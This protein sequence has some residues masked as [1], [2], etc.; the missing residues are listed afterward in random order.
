MGDYNERP[1]IFALS[2]PTSKAECTAEEAY[3]A[4][5]GRAVFASGSPFP[6]YEK[7]GLRFEP[8]QG[9]NA[10]IFPGVALATITAGIHHISEEV[11][12]IAAQVRFVARFGILNWEFITFWN[13]R[14]SLKPFPNRI[15][16]LGGN[17]ITH[18]KL[19]KLV[20]I[21]TSYFKFFRLYPP[22]QDIQN[23][24]IQIATAIVEDAYANGKFFSGKFC[25]WDNYLSHTN[26]WDYH[27]LITKYLYSK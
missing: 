8:G 21:L 14:N 16:K 12:I 26:Y 17:K 2:N 27:V 19:F 7:N 3:D 18:C 22:L 9:N 24:S 15:L 13:I 1:V 4:T 11:F 6:T 20:H 25:S 23:V 5:E 10:Y